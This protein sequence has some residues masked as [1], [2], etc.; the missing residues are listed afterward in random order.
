MYPGHPA[1]ELALHIARDRV[2]RVESIT[3]FCCQVGVQS[4]APRVLLVAFYLLVCP[5]NSQAQDLESCKLYH[6]ETFRTAG[7]NIK[8]QETHVPS[9]Q[10]R[11]RAWYLPPS[12]N[13]DTA[14]HGTTTAVLTRRLFERPVRQPCAWK[15]TRIPCG[16]FRTISCAKTG[17]FAKTTRTTCRH[18]Q[19]KIRSPWQ[20]FIKIDR[21]LGESTV[22]P[23]SISKKCIRSAAYP[24]P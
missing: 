8:P 24:S 11:V 6:R 13:S 20:G 12:S 14:I 17:C 7:R 22:L 3:L 19:H 23:P 9:V 21:L 16:R 1:T 18:R 4:T 2:D 15:A 10:Y 5:S